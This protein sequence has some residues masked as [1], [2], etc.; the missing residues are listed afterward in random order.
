MKNMSD[1]IGGLVLFVL[2][3]GTLIGS[4]FLKI[5]TPTEPQS[6]FFPFLGSAALLVFSAVI[7]FQGWL[8]KEKGQ[9]SGGDV[10]RP[11][12]LVVVLII[13]VAVL[14]LL[15]YVVATFIASGFILRIMGVKSWRVLIITGLCLSIGTYLLFDKLLGVELP[16]GALSR[17]GL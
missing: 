16:I 11:A 6:G 13:F 7:F 10:L 14:D 17:F 3:V 2:S 12:L 5:G 1:M 4:I 9:A 15:G 8:G